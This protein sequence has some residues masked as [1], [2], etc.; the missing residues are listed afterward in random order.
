M[1]IACVASPHGNDGGRQ[2][3]GV[4]KNVDEVVHRQE[5]SL[6]C[7]S[8]RYV[9]IVRETREKVVFVHKNSRWSSGPIISYYH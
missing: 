4:A 3:H 8:A 5:C 1:G 9:E 2:R 7:Q 6:A